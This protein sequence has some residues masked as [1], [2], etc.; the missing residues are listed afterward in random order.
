MIAAYLEQFRA[1]LQW[2]PD[3]VDLVDEAAD[4]L[5]E[6]T[7]HLVRAG[8][9]Q[10]TAQ[11]QTLARFGDPVLVARSFAL[12]R[13]GGIAMPTRFTHTAG[14]IGLASTAVWLLAAAGVWLGGTDLLADWNSAAYLLWAVLAGLAGL[15]SMVALAGLL[16]RSGGLRGW[17]PG[18]ALLA[19]G[20]GAVL[21]GVLT[22]AWPLSTG[23][24]AVAAGLVLWQLHAAG[25]TSSGYGWLLAA[26]WPTGIALFA[27]LTWMQVGPVDYWGD[28]PVAYAAGFTTGSVLFSTGLAHHSLR[29]RHEHPAD[30]PT[31]LAHA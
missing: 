8:A 20:A 2:H 29:L 1:S 15:G 4:H 30:L 3:A 13:H 7:R 28:Y 22:W 5:H 21:L 14:S 18:A 11:A 26:G 24:L 16:A 6:T 10:A 9:D 12:T 31:P 25:L 23:L 17:L 19:G 27:G